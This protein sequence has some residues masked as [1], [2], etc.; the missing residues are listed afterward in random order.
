MDITE[1][2]KRHYEKIILSV[3]LALLAVIFALLPGRIEKIRTQ[4]QENRDS[5]VKAAKNYQP[6]NIAEFEAALGK[7]TNV[8]AVKLSGGHNLFAPVLWI[9]DAN[10]QLVKVVS[11]KQ[12]GP[13]ALKV[14]KITPLHYILNLERVS[15]GSYTVSI[16]DESAIRAVDRKP[17]TRYVSQTSPKCEFFRL[18]EVKGDPADPTALVLELPGEEKKTVEIAKDKPYKEVR[19]YIADMKYDLENLT[20]T[21]KRVNDIISFAG[22]EYKIEDIRPNEVVLVSQTSTRRFIVKYTQQ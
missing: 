8:P 7:M 12:I 6:I 16:T 9:I 1:L 19:A 2:L 11:E 21:D 4:L 3:I 18:V 5:L 15:G 10:G 20:F 13:E 14:T 22:D 17:K